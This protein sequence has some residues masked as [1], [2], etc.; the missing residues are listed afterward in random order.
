M[1]EDEDVTRL[2]SALTRGDEDAAGKLI[3]AVY[4]ELRRLAG[5]Y[6]RRERTDHTLQA[7]ALVNEQQIGMALESQ[8][9]GFG[10]TRVEINAHSLYAIKIQRRFDEQPW[11]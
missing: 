4:D 6:M 5:S 3:P 10:F 7:T 2:L 11:Q 1:A 9:D 8:D